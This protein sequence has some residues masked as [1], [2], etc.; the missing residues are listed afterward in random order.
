MLLPVA[1]AFSA[2]CAG[3]VKNMHEMPADTADPTPAPGKALLVFLRPS[4]MGFAVQSSVF[5]VK[6]QRPELLGIVA[7][8]KKVAWQADPGQH[9]LLVVGESGDFMI[10]NLV[11][12]RTYYA[13]VTPRM[14]AW[15]A[16][17]SLKPVHKADLGT[18]EFRDWWTSCTWVEMDQS[19]QEWAKGN[20]QS[21]QG[22]HSEY[23]PKWMEKAPAE[24]PELLPDDGVP[25]R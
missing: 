9:L 23:Y 1:M 18:Q 8:K 16:R 14:G 22:T 19:S 2:G 3:S 20:L 24:R 5:E 17:F 6:D 25:V 21:I 15:K 11:A 13:L 4:G 12:G 10:A 7:A